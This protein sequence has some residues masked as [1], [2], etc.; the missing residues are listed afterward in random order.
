MKKLADKISRKKGLPPGTL[1]HV[2]EQKTEEVKILV[3][4]YN[5]QDFNVCDVKKVNECSHSYKG[6]MTK[7]IDVVGIHDVNVIAEIGS[8]YNL[9]PLVMEDILNTNQRPKVDDWGE[10]TYI[11]LKMLHFDGKTGEIVPEQASI[12]LGEKLVITFQE[13]KGDDFLPVI[14]R[15]INDQGRIRKTGADYLAY[16]LLDSIIDNYFGILEKL[17]EKIETLEAELIEKPTQ[18]TVNTIHFLKREMIFL[19]KSVWP[20]R[21]VIAAL[22]RGE[23]SR[24]GDSTRMYVKDIYDHVIQIIDTIE[25]FRDML[26]GMIDI[27]LSSINNRMNQVMKLLTIIT[28]IFI[29]LSFITGIYGMNFSY[30]PGFELRYGVLVVLTAMVLIAVFMLYFFKKK[31]W[32]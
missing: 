10:Y 7:W 23:S 9:H 14:D 17:G 31:K 27:Y 8:L 12:I 20:L 13:T 18:E 26:S 6:E 15:I 3:I 28:T 4:E 21:E 24:I 25:L 32:F 11:V 2:G 16:A 29:P 22:E 30:I 1:V 19:R 5:E